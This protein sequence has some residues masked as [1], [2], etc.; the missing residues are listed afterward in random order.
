MR[1]PWRV[2][3]NDNLTADGSTYAEA[4]AAILRVMKAL[5]ELDEA[6]DYASTLAARETAIQQN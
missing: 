3:A 1:P 5:A 2:V 4:E 6:D